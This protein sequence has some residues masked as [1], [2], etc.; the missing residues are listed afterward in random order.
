MITIISSQKF[1]VPILM[2]HRVLTLD[3]LELGKKHFV[4]KMYALT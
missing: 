3:G 2:Q 4:Q 1:G